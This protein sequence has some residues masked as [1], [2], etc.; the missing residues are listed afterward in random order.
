MGFW[1]I[2]VDSMAWSIGLGLLFAF[3]FRKAAVLATSGV[4]GGLQN[5][6]EMIFEFIDDTTRSIFEAKPQSVSDVQA[7]T[8]DPLRRGWSVYHKQWIAGPD[9]G[10]GW[11]RAMGHTHG[12]RRG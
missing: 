9:G 8:Y 12:P 4:P 10:L 2:N 5:A 1:S 3:L 6:V 7:L 11:R